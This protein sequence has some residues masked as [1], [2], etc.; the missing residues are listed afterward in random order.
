MKVKTVDL[1]GDALDWA[2]AKAEGHDVD[3]P[4]WWP[5]FGDESCYS[6]DWADGGP[7]IEREEISLDRVASALWIATRVEG[8]AVCEAWGTTQLEAAMRCYVMSQLGDEVEI[9]EELK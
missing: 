5:D 3:D 9:P 1:T 8:S 6:S 4:T 2:V 7:V